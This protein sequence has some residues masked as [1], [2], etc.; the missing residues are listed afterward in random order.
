MK[1]AA[2]VVGSHFSGKSKTI[3]KY[4]KPLVGLQENQRAFN[5]MGHTGT[6][7]SQSVE[8]KGLGRVISQ[9]IEEKQPPNLNDFLSKYLEFKWLVLAARPE[10][11]KKSFLKEII[12]M[13]EKHGYSVAIINVTKGQPESFYKNRA[14]EIFEHLQ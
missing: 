11:E 13:L 8:E 12:A 5:L 14:K 4:F 6:I 1:K 3:K 7:L 10:N 9:S 2:I